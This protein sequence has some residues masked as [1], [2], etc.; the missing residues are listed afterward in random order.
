MSDKSD[1]DYPK[2]VIKPMED[3]QSKLAHPLRYSPS[4]TTYISDTACLSL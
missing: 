2:R 3:R 4:H 1:Y